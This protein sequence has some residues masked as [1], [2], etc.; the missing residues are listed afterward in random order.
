M[1]FKV[2]IIFLAEAEKLD[3]SLK[4]HHINLSFLSVVIWAAPHFD[5]T[6]GGLSR[7]LN[8]LHAKF[9]WIMGTSWMQRQHRLFL[10]VHVGINLPLCGLISLCFQLWKLSL[11]GTKPLIAE[12]SNNTTNDR[13]YL[14]VVKTE[15]QKHTMVMKPKKSNWQLFLQSEVWAVWHENDKEGKKH[16]EV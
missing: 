15:K 2:T 8:K 12:N 6:P 11:N 10:H 7:M 5:E 9:A 3:V 14:K 13:I 1:S 16:F 4:L